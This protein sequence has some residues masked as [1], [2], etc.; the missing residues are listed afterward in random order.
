[1]GILPRSRWFKVKRCG[2]HGSSR[3]GTF[4]TT[5]NNR[6]LQS[7]GRGSNEVQLDGSCQDE[8]EEVKAAFDLFDVD[9]TQRINPKDAFDG[10]LA[11]NKRKTGPVGTN[12]V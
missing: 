6:G 3:K 7:V 4:G 11:C 8:I 1:M 5:G 12:Y 2:F 9:G 10:E